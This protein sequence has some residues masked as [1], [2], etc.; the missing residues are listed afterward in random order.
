M[1]SGKS[2]GTTA[3]DFEEFSELDLK[4]VD[5]ARSRKGF[6]VPALYKTAPSYQDGLRP[7]DVILSLDGRHFKST[8]ELNRYI[9][10]R[11]SLDI[12]IE[13]L[14]RGKILYLKTKLLMEQDLK[15]CRTIEELRER[16]DFGDPYALL[17]L[18]NSLKQTH[19]DF[20]GIERLPEAERIA[21]GRGR[22]LLVGLFGSSVCCVHLAPWTS[23][24]RE[25]VSH[26]LVQ[27]SI[28]N[29]YTSLLVVKPEAYRLYRLYRIDSRFP[30]FLRI[31]WQGALETGLS[32]QPENS[33]TDLLSFL[34]RKTIR[35]DSTI[36]TIERQ[37]L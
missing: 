26:S 6:G 12:D 16:A 35:P 3:S 9:R 17:E 31:A 33:V 7:G 5:L 21:E 27:E 36:S 2:L 28:V 20:L 19:W 23:P 30:A 22:P 15:E 37:K 11:P 34:G 10:S 18:H 8:M 13:F 24:Y 4:G 32:L 25:I 29:D 1:S 14:R